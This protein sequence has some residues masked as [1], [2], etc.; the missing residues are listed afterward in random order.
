MSGAESQQFEENDEVEQTA[1]GEGSEAG[2]KTG[3]EE[4][5]TR[6]ESEGQAQNMLT[7][8][9][10]DPDVQRVLQAKQNGKPL[11]IS[12]GEETAPAE[13][14][15]EI[16]AEKLNE[17]SNSEFLGVVLKKMEKVVGSTIPKVMKPFEDKLASVEGFLESK[18][19]KGIQERIQKMA[20]D[21]PDFQRLRPVMKEINDHTPGLELDELYFL[22][23][24]R[25]GLPLAPDRSASSERPTVGMHTK[26]PQ[27][28]DA[29]KKPLPP[30]RS[31]FDQ[32]LSETL[33]KLEFESDDMD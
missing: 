13:R 19:K 30:G 25:S 17:M 6:M 4:R 24:K 10:T 16:D 22:A 11:K 33:D 27:R 3:L 28:Q 15:E 20:K 12:E 7:R 18:E 14:E 23:R 29:R 8:L 31:G 21:L 1:E 32:L 2:G 26:A 5:I 9:M